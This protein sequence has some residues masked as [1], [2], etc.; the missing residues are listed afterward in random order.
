AS[1]LNPANGFNFTFHGPKGAMSQRIDPASVGFKHV[2]SATI[3]ER[4]AAVASAMLQT[5]KAAWE[6]GQAGGTLFF[7]MT[8]H[9]SPGGFTSTQDGELEFSSIASAIK[10]ARGGVPL[11]RL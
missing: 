10:Q 4:T 7:Y 9:G 3:I 5:D 1:V 2:N 8:S 6:Q 11:Q